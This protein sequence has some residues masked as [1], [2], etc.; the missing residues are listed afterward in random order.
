LDRLLAD[1][2]AV[3]NNYE[4]IYGGNF[5]HHGTCYASVY[6]NNPPLH[7]LS[8]FLPSFAPFASLVWFGLAQTD[9]PAYSNAYSFFLV[10][11]LGYGDGG[12]SPT[13]RHDVRFFPFPASL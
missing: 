11:V 8:L 1:H 2:L 13:L 7:F 6:K 12:I 9:D 10:Q 5:V 4:N 3:A